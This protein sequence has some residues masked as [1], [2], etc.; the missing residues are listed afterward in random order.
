MQLEGGEKRAMQV[1]KKAQGKQARESRTGGKKLPR[2]SVILCTYNRRNLVLSALASLRRQTLSYNLFEVI[3]VDNG[4]SDGTLQAVR[5]YVNAGFQE[6]RRIEDRW[7]VQCLAEPQNGLAY[8]RITGLLAAV[9][10]IAVFLDDDTL[11]DPY[12]LERLLQAYDET[13]ADAIGGHVELRWEAPR[14]YWLPDDSLNLLGYFNPS[15]ER[16]RLNQPLNIHTGEQVVVPE[17]VLTQPLLEDITEH[18]MLSEG[19]ASERLRDGLD[20]LR[21]AAP[22]LSMTQSAVHVPG[23]TSFSSCCFSVRVEALHRAGSVAPFA[24]FLSKRQQL[25]TNLEVY[26]LCQRLH[27]TGSHLWYEPLAVVTHRVPAARLKR[28]FFTGRAYWQ[29]RSEITMQYAS[30]LTSRTK[31]KQSSRAILRAIGRECFEIAGLALFYRPLLRLAGHP[32]GE[33]LQAAMEQARHWG[34][35]HQYLQILEHAPLEITKLAVL[36]IDP[37]TAESE[38]DPAIELLAEALR[39]QGVSCTISTADIPVS[40]LWRHRANDGYAIGVI[41]VYQP[42]MLNLNYR[43]WQRFSFRLWLAKRWSI[44]L[45]TTDGGGWWQSERGLS[46]L[47]RRTLERRLLYNSAHVLTSTRLPDQ[48]YPHKRLR[49]RARCLPQPG[50]RGYYAPPLPR[51][52]AQ[53]QLGLSPNAAFVYLC[54]A[55]QHTARELLLLIEAFSRLTASIAETERAKGRSPQLLLA[56]AIVDSRLSTRILKLAAQNPAISLSLRTPGKAEIPLYLGAAD[57]LVL[58]HFAIAQAGRLDTAMLALSY[59]R[60]IVAPDLPRFQGM[61]PPAACLFYNP[62]SRDSLVQALSKAPS[63]HYSLKPQDADALDA[64]AGWSEYARRLIKIYQEVL[65]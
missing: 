1:R 40:W 26:D 44:P 2:L 6:V 8:A 9:G 52:D 48:L 51:A 64:S 38:R 54:L 58:P 56:G 32:S 14:P 21:D 25:P 29:G 4:S 18:V 53:R 15:N 60:I 28:A 34:R 24:P 55:H 19:A 30:K 36:L 42:G 13:G 65:Q 23:F 47:A 3:I 63:H 57:A 17:E 31:E 27:E 61:L 37:G 5:A 35:A 46:H 20:G 33:Q 43:Q 41:H 11:A 59:E 16:V 7:Q 62:A 39:S 49:R 50:F 10:E 22:S 45:V 12:F